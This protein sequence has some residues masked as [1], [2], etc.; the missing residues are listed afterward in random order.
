MVKLAEQLSGDAAHPATSAQP[1]ADEGIKPD[2]ARAHNVVTQDAGQAEQAKLPLVRPSAIEESAL[3]TPSARAQQ[4]LTP[5]NIRVDESAVPLSAPQDSSWVLSTAAALGVVIAL[6]LGLRWLALRVRG[7]NM[8]VRSPV[9]EV[10]SRSVVGPKSAVLL[11]R[12]GPRVLIVGDSSGGL[13]TLSEVHDEQE[14]A[15]LLQSIEAG[16]PQSMT[17]SFQ[18]VFSRLNKQFD[19]DEPSDARAEG[20]DQS[21]HRVDRVRDSLSSLK[22]KMR[23]SGPGEGKGVNG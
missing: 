14:V 3:G 1:P 12:V 23:W 15:S 4:A 20:L 5:S 11:L 8:G 9:V 6:I 7:V 2:S 17:H 22:S 13:R 21:E 16:R 18:G 10:L 19:A